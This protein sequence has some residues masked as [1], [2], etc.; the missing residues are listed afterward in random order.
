MNWYKKLLKLSARVGDYWILPDGKELQVEHGHIHTGWD[1]LKTLEPNISED[2]KPKYSEDY[3]AFGKRGWVRMAFYTWINIFSPLPLPYPQAK[4]IAELAS[5]NP[6]A[7]E[8][9]MDTL[10]GFKQIKNHVKAIINYLTTTKA[11]PVVQQQVP[12]PEISEFDPQLTKVDTTNPW[13]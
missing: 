13:A 2:E 4:K 5:L 12:I 8:L 1:Y 7:S 6:N 9:G 10:D 3:Q 11:A